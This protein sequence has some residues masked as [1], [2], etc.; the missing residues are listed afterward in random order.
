MCLSLAFGLS[1]FSRSTPKAMAV[2]PATFEML[3]MSIRYSEAAGDDGIRF[4]VELDLTTYAALEA[5]N[6]AV[7]GILITPSDKISGGSLTLWTAAASKAAYG[8]LYNGSDGTNNWNVDEYSATG[9]VYLHG[10]PE[11][12]YN[13]PIT[14]VAY[15]DWNNDGAVATVNHSDTVEKSMAD[16][17]LAVTE[18]YE[19]SN[20]FGTTAEQADKL[21]A[22]MPSYDVD[23]LDQY[24]N[25]IETKTTKFGSEFTFPSDPSIVDGRT[26]LGWQKRVGGTAGSPVW[27]DGLINKA[28]ENRTVKKAAQYK[29]YYQERVQYTT[30]LYN[31]E[32]IFGADPSVT[33]R[34]GYYYYVTVDSN[35]KILVRKSP[36]LEDL[37]NGG[38]NGWGDGIDFTTVYDPKAPS[39]NYS[40]A[41]AKKVWAPELEYLNGKWYIYVSG[42]SSSSSGENGQVMDERMFV[43]ECNSQDPT[44]SWKTPVQLEP[45]VVS[46]KYAID[47]HAFYYKGQLYYTFSGRTTNSE[48]VSPRIFICTMNS[49]TSVN[50]DAVNIS[51]NSPLEEGP[52]TLVDGNDLYLMYSVGNYAGDTR[53]NKDYHVDYYKCSNKNPM[54][55]GNWTQGGTAIWHSPSNDVYCTGHNHIFKNADG[56]WWTSY[57]GVVGTDDIGEEEYLAKRRVMVQ[58]I[59]VTEGV[60]SFGNFRSSVSI[61]DENGLFYNDYEKTTYAV[62]G[63]GS[64]RLWEN[65]GKSFTVSAR[66]TRASGS[67]Q[68]CAGI[69]LYQRRGDGYLSK[70]LIGVE[71][72]G[73]LFLCN[74]YRRDPYYYKYVGWLASN[75]G[76]YNLSVTYTAGA[77]ASDS[78]IKIDVSDSSGSLSLSRSY[79][80]AAINAFVSDTVP[81]SDPASKAYDLHFVPGNFGIGLGGNLN[82]CLFDNVSFYSNNDVELTWN[83]AWG[84]SWSAY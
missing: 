45:S 34:N 39:A 19:G 84:N 50:N 40:S 6:N 62:D 1:T 55:A 63:Y 72:E 24:G 41:L 60:L 11:A 26:F 79:T 77:T 75:L 2:E 42:C 5:D 35:N 25:N 61:T 9:I 78:T 32:N 52:C 57:H 28:S 29:A 67:D 59:S 33:Y 3:G 37:L 71:K 8:I 10:F 27:S 74:D 21:D 81:D 49:P 36:S 51:K 30:T 17:A 46:G 38:Y 18:D 64:A 7:A 54:S 23:F 48:L 12:S 20:L 47:G 80:L 53:D 13:R 15:I 43:L 22:Y 76:T 16:V 83:G 31:K 68:Y 82:K 4:G 66:I 65:S 58:P 14:A 73:N 56:S 70:L 44:G 69:T